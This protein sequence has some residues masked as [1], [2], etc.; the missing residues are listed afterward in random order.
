[1]RVKKVNE[2]ISFERGDT[3]ERMGV[4]IDGKYYECWI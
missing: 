4:G 3:K 2:N 1:M